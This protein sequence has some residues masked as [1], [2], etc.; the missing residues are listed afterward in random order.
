MKF[1]LIEQTEHNKQIK[2]MPQAARFIKSV[3]FFDIPEASLN[4]RARELI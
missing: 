1:L 2:A 4:G 3:M